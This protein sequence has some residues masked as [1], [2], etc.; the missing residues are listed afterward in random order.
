M[1]FSSEEDKK[2]SSQKAN[3]KKLYDDLENSIK[4]FT[5]I[6][7]K[8]KEHV[9]KTLEK[10]TN[11]KKEWLNDMIKAKDDFQKE[12]SGFFDTSNEMPKRTTT[13][14]TNDFLNT[15]KENEKDE[16]IKRLKEKIEKQRQL[17]NE[18]KIAITNN[19]NLIKDYKKELKAKDDKISSL[20]KQLI[21]IQK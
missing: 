9:E 17:I 6:N 2:K 18:Q 20:N 8:L 15:N 13:V 3:S 4:D 16:E 5:N 11:N 7:I 19:T 1:V 10:F 21:N 12:I 14:T